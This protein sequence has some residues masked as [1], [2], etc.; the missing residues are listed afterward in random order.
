LTGTENKG[1]NETVASDDSGKVGEFSESER[2]E[3]YR[4]YHDLLIGEHTGISRIYEGLQPYVSWPNM[5]RDIE[6]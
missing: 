1:R 4:E 5:R 3:H 6:N 2:N